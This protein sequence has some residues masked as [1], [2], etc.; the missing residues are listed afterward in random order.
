[1]KGLSQILS[2][3]K[4]KVFRLSKTLVY[5]AES[6]NTSAEIPHWR[7]MDHY[8]ATE[9]CWK[10]FQG[11]FRQHILVQDFFKSSTVFIKIVYSPFWRK[12]NSSITWIS[13]K[14]Q[15][16]SVKIQN[17]EKQ[18]STVFCNIE[19]SSN[20]QFVSLKVSFSTRT[21][22]NGSCGILDAEI[23]KGNSPRWE[24]LFYKG[25]SMYC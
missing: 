6:W 14:M 18:H 20:N 15:I 23:C 13:D 16:I 5:F 11:K 25:I 10:Q 21:I 2:K 4:Q 7:K 8:M 22:H 19:F 12:A 3:D 1:M 17:K 24:I 9:F